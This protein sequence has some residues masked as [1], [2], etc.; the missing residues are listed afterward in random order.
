MLENIGVEVKFA[1]VR[2]SFLENALEFIHVNMV[3]LNKEYK[4]VKIGIQAAI[5]F[6]QGNAVRVGNEDFQ[7]S[8][9]PDTDD[10]LLVSFWEWD[11]SFQRNR[12]NMDLQLPRNLHDGFVQRVWVNIVADKVNVNR[13]A[14]TT[15]QSQRASAYQNQSRVGRNA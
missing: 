5:Q 10:A 6:T 12:L 4:I 1:G 13:Q 9:L 11:K 8:K 2:Q 7:I 15:E 3:I 14:R